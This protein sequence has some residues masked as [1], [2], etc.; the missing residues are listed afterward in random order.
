M[1]ALERLQSLGSAPAAGPQAGQ[2]GR[3]A[4]PSRDRRPIPRPA[5]GAAAN[6]TVARIAAPVVFLVAVIVLI[7]LLFQSG[8]VGGQDEARVTKPKPAVTKT[9]KA[10]PKPATAGSTTKVYVV[11][12]G[13]TPSGIADKYGI[14]MSELEALNPDKD[15]TTLVVG[16][17]VKVPK[18]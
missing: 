8:V 3:I 10:T 7:S 17:K 5:G 4:S 9:K 13:D 2:S 1:A 6:L 11:K 12:T 15:F 14:S 16:E 18:R